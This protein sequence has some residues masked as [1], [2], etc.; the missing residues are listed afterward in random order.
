MSSRAPTKPFFE[1][2]EVGL[3][4]KSPIKAPPGARFWRLQM[5]VVA[6]VLSFAFPDSEL[7]V[8]PLMTVALFCYLGLS[9]SL[10]LAAGGFDLGAGFF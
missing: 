9:I 7:E 4:R 5:A 6:R 10:L 3:K 8:G 2:D 1:A